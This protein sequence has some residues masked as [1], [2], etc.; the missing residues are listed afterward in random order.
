VSNFW[1]EVHIS[2]SDRI[3]LHPHPLY[4]PSEFGSLSDLYKVCKKEGYMG[5]MRLLQATLKK[6]AEYCTLHGIALSQRNFEVRYDTNIPK[7]VGLA[8]S[9]AIVSALF[10]GLMKFYGLTSMDIPLESQPSFVLSVEEELGIN[11]GL[12]DRVMQIYEGCVYMNFDKEM[13]LSNNHG[14]KCFLE[15]LLLFVD[16]K[17]WLT[18]ISCCF[19]SLIIYVCTCMCT[20]I[21]IIYIY[22]HM[23]VYT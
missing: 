7:Q 5:G 22:V 3:I 14:M 1:A 12:Q 18:L 10:K 2:Q 17:S 23:Y 13:L 20:C 9:S 8:G 19:L 11:A 16:Q 21:C 6:F 15:L 4:D